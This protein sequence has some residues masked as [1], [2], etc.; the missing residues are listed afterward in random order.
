ME[1]FDESDLLIFEESREI[2]ESLWKVWDLL[3]DKEIINKIIMNSF[4]MRELE[5]IIKQINRNGKKYKIIFNL[6]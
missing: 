1:E 4:L 6:K 2:K 3:N 5:K